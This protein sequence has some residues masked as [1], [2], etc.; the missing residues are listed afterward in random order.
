MALRALSF[1]GIG[2]D[3]SLALSTRLVSGIGSPHRQ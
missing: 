2:M 1:P 3:A